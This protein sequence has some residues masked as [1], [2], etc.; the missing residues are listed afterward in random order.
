MSLASPKT[1][2]RAGLRAEGIRD[3]AEMRCRIFL[4]F[5]GDDFSESQKAKIC[6]Y[7]REHT[8]A[9]SRPA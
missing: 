1:L 5:Y 4:R 2:A 8:P 7:L 3:G 6:A 9:E